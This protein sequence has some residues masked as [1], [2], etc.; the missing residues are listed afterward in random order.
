MR[1]CDICGSER[2]G[3]EYF[4]SLT[5]WP[6]MIEG[7]ACSLCKVLC[8]KCLNK[9]ETCIKTIKYEEEDNDTVE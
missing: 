3:N 1:N 6:Y 2:K 4:Y 8:R 5:A 9:L 7:C